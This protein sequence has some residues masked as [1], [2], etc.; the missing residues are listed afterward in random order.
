MSNVGIISL[1]HYLPQRR[2]TNSDLEKMV[3]TTDEWITTRTGIKER[4]VASQGEKTSTLATL[5]A[6]EAIKNAGIDPETIDLIIVATVSPDSN[7]PS[8]A[9]RVQRAIGAKNATAFDISAACAGYLY[10][11][12]TAKQY[13]QSK[14]YKT[15]LVIAAERITS[16][17]DW[18][19]RNT[20]VLFGDGAGA[21][22]LSQVDGPGIISEYLHSEGELG[23]LMSVVSDESREPLSQEEMMIKMPYV[24]M[25]GKELFK[26]AVNSMSDAIEIAAKKAKINLSDIACVVPHQAN[27][28][29]ISAVAKKLEIPKE[30]I[31]VNIDRYG[32]MSAASIA[33]AL[34]EAVDQK[35]IR[36]GDHVALVAFGAGLVSAASVFVW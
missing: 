4:R 15:A 31:F 13:I 24:V 12:T 36:K 5:A 20:C 14:F 19:D 32:N 10:A 6:E 35:H 17:I 21:C 3:D 7:F 18:K 26:V 23:D 16:L 27:D 9:C 25:Q 29:I 8:M 2:L 22:I 1:G 34:Y 28:R 11:L 30:K 33:V